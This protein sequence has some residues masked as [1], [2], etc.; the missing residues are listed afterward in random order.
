MW[1][2]FIYLIVKKYKLKTQSRDS[3]SISNTLDI[4]TLAKR[5]FALIRKKLRNRGQFWFSVSRFVWYLQKLILDNILFNS[6]IPFT[7]PWFSFSDRPTVFPY[8]PGKP[9]TLF[10]G[11]IT[12]TPSFRNIENRI[13]IFFFDSEW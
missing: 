2:S 10:L 6:N 7:I 1:T 4:K 3:L 12:Y 8:P 11:R 5:N 9:L 13:S